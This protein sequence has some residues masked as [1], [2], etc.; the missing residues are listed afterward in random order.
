MVERAISP[1]DSSLIDEYTVDI[2]LNDSVHWENVPERVWDYTLGGYQ[3][4]RK[5]LSYRETQALGRTLKA[6]EAWT[7]TKIARRIAAILHM[8]DDLDVSYRRCATE[9]WDWQAAV[10]AAKPQRPMFGDVSS[11]NG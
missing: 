8:E 11:R 9:T 10:D 5:W 2:S 1:G 6:D 7:F 4:L 3:V